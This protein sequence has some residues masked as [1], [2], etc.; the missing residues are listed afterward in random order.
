LLELDR[1]V[2]VGYLS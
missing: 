1:A 2:R